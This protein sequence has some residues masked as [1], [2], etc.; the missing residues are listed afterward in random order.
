MDAVR[1]NGGMGRMRMF[2]MIACSLL[3]VAGLAEPA[4][5][6]IFG[7]V[8]YEVKERY[9]ADNRYTATFKAPGDLVVVRLKNGDTWPERPDVL[10]F[11]VNGK[12][13]LREARYEH[14]VIATFAQLPGENS[15]EVFVKDAKP[16]GMR[17][18]KPTP[19]FTTLSVLRSPISGVEGSFGGVTYEQIIEYV[20]TIK[21]ITRPDALAAVVTAAGLQ[22]E[23]A[24]RASASE[25]FLK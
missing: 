17:R 4:D 6:T 13:I 18:P 10:S 8:K 16:S 2:I 23:H 3:A 12:E 19:K 25:R 22:N 5:R 14:P 24:V 9:G 7:P 1:E 15:L 21:R 11:S 20:K